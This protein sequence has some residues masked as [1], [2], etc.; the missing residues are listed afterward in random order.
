[1]R[2]GSLSFEV[3]LSICLTLV[4]DAEFVFVEGLVFK[5]SDGRYNDFR[6][7]WVKLK[8]DYIAGLGD[9]VDLAIVGAGWEK[10]WS[11]SEARRG[12]VRGQRWRTI[13]S[14]SI[15][16]SADHHRV[17]PARQSQ[18]ADRTGA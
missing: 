16:M 9:T 2:E 5:A 12:R 7:P 13:M 4:A 11:V 1:M 15:M 17:E 6:S 3:S 8:K 18:R 14:I 10:G